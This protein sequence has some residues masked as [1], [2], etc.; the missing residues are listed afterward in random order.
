MTRN[1]G[2]D[3]ARGKYVMFLDSDDY[4]YDRLDQ[5]INE[6]TGEDIVYYGLIENDGTKIIPTMFNNEVVCGT[7]K[8]IKR[9][10][11]GDT[12]YPDM[13]FAEDWHFNKLLLEK[14]P[15]LKFTNIY[16]LHYN[17]PR[18]NSLFDLGARK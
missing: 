13:N 16:L 18:K 5:F 8:A 1:I 17:H 4:L 10:F 2:I 15:T 7:V 3:N 14:N 12:R 11:I 6:L 9:E